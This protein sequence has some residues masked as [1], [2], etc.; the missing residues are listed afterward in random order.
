MPIAVGAVPGGLNDVVGMLSVHSLHDRV[1]GD[2]APERDGRGPADREIFAGNVG[3]ATHDVLVRER[4]V[5][6]NQA[7]GLR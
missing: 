7:S 4:S 5:A 3:H 1:G 6:D 2:L